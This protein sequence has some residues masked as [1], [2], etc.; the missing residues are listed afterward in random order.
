MKKKKLE[1]M[2]PEEIVEEL[3]KALE[4]EM[5]VETYPQK[6]AR[7]GVSVE[8]QKDLLRGIWFRTATEATRIKDLP[9]GE[10]M[11]IIEAQEQQDLPYMDKLNELKLEAIM[12]GLNVE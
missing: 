3:R 5:E 1:D 11:E 2:T 7:M 12:R 10:L 6:L 4:T 8:E 9:D